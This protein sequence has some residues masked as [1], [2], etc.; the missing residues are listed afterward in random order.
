MTSLVACWKCQGT[1]QYLHFG[2]CYA[3]KGTGKRLAPKQQTGKAWWMRECICL[4]PSVQDVLCHIHSYDECI[5]AR[6][7]AGL[8]RR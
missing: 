5:D 3:C 8:V 1:G 4:N 6:E 2:T 7:R